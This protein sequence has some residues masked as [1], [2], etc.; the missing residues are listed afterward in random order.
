MNITKD[1]ID[2]CKETDVVWLKHTARQ[3][4]KELKACRK[5]NARLQN[6]KLKPCS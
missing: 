6:F 2:S 1:D 4:V 5:E 3:L